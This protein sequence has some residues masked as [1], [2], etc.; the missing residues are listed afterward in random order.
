MRSLQAHLLHAVLLLNTFLVLSSYYS[1]AQTYSVKD[2][3]ALDGGYSQAQAINASG[4]VVGYAQTSAPGGAFLYNNG[5]VTSRGTLGGSI[6]LDRGINRW[7]DV[8]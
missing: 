2:L 1:N 3:G 5:S 7:G 6:S 4:E 8:V